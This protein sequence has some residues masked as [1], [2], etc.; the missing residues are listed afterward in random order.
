MSTQRT[1]ALSPPFLVASGST[2]ICFR[3]KSMQFQSKRQI[4][5]RAEVR[6]TFPMQ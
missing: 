1:E 3:L 4:S 5:V 2:S 6:R